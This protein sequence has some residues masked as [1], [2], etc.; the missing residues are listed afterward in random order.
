MQECREACFESE[1][2]RAEWCEACRG[3][4]RS[5]QALSRGAVIGQVYQIGRVLGQGGFATTYLGWD[6]RLG[7]LVAIKEYLPSDF[8]VRTTHGEVT[9]KNDAR[10]ATFLEYRNKFIAEAQ[11]LARL[12]HP[13]IVQILRLEE[14]SGTAYIIMPFIAGGSLQAR[15]DERMARKEWWSPAEVVANLQP[16]AEALTYIHGLTPPLLHRDL[17][18]DNI[19]L[20]RETAG[21]RALLLDFGISRHEYSTTRGV[22][23]EPTKGS[24][25]Y[26]F[27]PLEQESGLSG[28][29]TAATDVYGLAA[30]MYYLLTDQPPVRAVHRLPGGL[31]EQ[32]RLVPLSTLR[33]DVPARV[34]ETIMSGLALRAADR[35]PT[36]ET[37]M[38]GLRE[39]ERK[40][41][42]GVAK[43]RQ[44]TFAGIAHIRKIVSR[45]NA[46]VVPTSS[47]A[48]R[49]LGKPVATF[50]GTLALFV[51]GVY[52][53]DN[54]NALTSGGGAQDPL[55]FVRRQPGVRRADAEA[56]LE[57]VAP[58]EG[59]I[60]RS[61]LEGAGDTC[62]GL[63]QYLSSPESPGRS[64]RL[65][66]YAYMAGCYGGL[67]EA[68][69]STAVMI[70]DGRGI[71]QNREQ[72]EAFCR[73]AF[74]IVEAATQC[75]VSVGWPSGVP[76][77]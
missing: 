38:A 61:C 67:A 34:A 36:V 14:E 3:E 29:Q 7:A 73:E 22:S 58:S 17:K 70:H 12:R 56:A 25:T 60:A 68:C 51:F 31:G 28:K 43:R 2:S 24:G 48:V 35:I 6:R 27:M 19:F 62:L 69:D 37:L 49:R 44:R 5:V 39:P 42:G 77:R 64:L 71:T 53:L 13:A 8:A 9:A 50:L 54:V 72:A 26:G 10:D 75:G 46:P 40:G 4:R 55:F 18:P 1:R 57:S 65:A 15:H 16:V 66:T 45:L 76:Y 41:G 59:S 74:R 20:R 11:L 52:M 23:R 21:E 47:K 33:P 32:D 63:A 30:T